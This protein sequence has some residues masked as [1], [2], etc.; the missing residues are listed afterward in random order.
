MT[1]LIVLLMFVVP[2]VLSLFD[3][4]RTAMTRKHTRDYS[5]SAIAASV[6]ALILLIGAALKLGW[7]R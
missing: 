7:S 3:A 4:R 5:L 6:G 2:C 1:V